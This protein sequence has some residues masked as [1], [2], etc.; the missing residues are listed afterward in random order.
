MRRMM[1]DVA[2]PPGQSDDAE[3]QLVV[4]AQAA[5]DAYAPA[6]L[7]AWAGDSKRFAEWCVDQRRVSLP[8]TPT[9]VADFV[10]F[11]ASH[12]KPAT[13]RRYLASIARQHIAANLADPTKAEKVRLAMRAC[14]RRTDSRQRQA[15]PITLSEEALMVAAAGTDLRG[16]RDSALLVVGRDLLARR[17]ELVALRVEDVEFDGKGTGVALIRRSKTDQ[18]GM[19]AVQ[20]LSARAVVRLRAWLSASAISS[21]PIFR[22]VDRWGR[23][24]AARASSSPVGEKR[25]LGLNP[26]EV[27]V[28]LRRLAVRAGLSPAGISGHSLRVGMAQDLASS[29]A[30]LP[31][32]MQAGRWKTAA[33]PARYIEKLDADKSAVAQFRRATTRTR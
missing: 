14:L 22:K 30:E 21:G 13:V 11:L 7:R 15:R 31:A 10:R 19:G 32:L 12:R 2:L 5:A 4:H 27:G 25:S 24:R 1:E 29:G 20:H 17:S 28:I 8:A 26:G 3:R 18:A 6:T 16:L 23:V 9:T 33:M